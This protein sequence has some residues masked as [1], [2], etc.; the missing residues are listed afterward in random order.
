MTRHFLLS[1][2]L[3]AASAF[4]LTIA[5]PAYACGKDCDCAKRHKASATKP[6]AK[7]EAKPDAKSQPKPAAA[8]PEKKAEGSGKCECTKGGKGCTCPKG[9]C[10]CPNCGASKYAAG[11]GDKKGCECA[12]G[13]D[14]AC[15]KDACKCHK[16]AKPA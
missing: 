15:A 14:C 10:K 13:K 11:T 16:A 5:T 12:K 1:A 9:E 8:A 6:D 4:A 7:P 3:A 2:A